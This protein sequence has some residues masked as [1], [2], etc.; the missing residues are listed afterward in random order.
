MA[1]VIRVRCWAQR[2]LPQTCCILYARDDR[3]FDPG[4]GP[5]GRNRAVRGFP[6]RDR[7]GTAP[8]P[9]RPHLG[10]IEAATGLTL[11]P[12][13]PHVGPAD[14]PGGGA[15]EV[16]RLRPGLLVEDPNAEGGA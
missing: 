6:R 13:L 1:A 11:R 2:S 3:A 10:G 5:Y 12:P 7:E 14:G 9:S 4:L 15:V 16:E 8:Q